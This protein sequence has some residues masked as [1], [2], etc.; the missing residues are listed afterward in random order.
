MATSVIVEDNPSL[1]VDIFKRGNILKTALG[2]VVLVTKDG[3]TGTYF[4]GTSLLET[5]TSNLGAYGVIWCVGGA[6][7]FKGTITLTEG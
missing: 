3:H 4:Q 2:N 6:K 1:T 7:L 5:T